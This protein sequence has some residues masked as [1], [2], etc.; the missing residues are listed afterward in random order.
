MFF[1]YYY[2]LLFDDGDVI[3][4]LG[5]GSFGQVWKGEIWGMNGLNGTTVSAV[6]TLK[7]KT[8]IPLNQK[9][10]WTCTG[11]VTVPV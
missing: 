2:Y 6:K 10:K 4:K 9:Q 7:G 8:T 1:H 11:E 5:E 3:S